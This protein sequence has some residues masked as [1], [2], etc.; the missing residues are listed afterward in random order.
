MTCRADGAESAE[1][2]EVPARS[3]TRFTDRMSITGMRGVDL[4]AAR[5]YRSD[6]VGTPVETGE[7]LA[8]EGG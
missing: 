6:E 4:D 2:F 7:I 1:T 3:L 5:A 8:T